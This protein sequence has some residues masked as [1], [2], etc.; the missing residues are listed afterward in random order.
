[1]ITRKPTNTSF[2][3]GD[4]GGDGLIHLVRQRSRQFSHHGHSV[5]VGEILQRL[6]QSLSLSLRLPAI[7]H[8]HDGTHELN[9]IAG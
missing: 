7:G 8:V 6:A 2:G 5:D 4:G 3:V 9:D 1:M